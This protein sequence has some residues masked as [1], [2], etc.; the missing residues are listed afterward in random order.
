MGGERRLFEAERHLCADALLGELR[1][2]PSYTLR[3]LF[4]FTESAPETG[5]SQT[6][7]R[8]DGNVINQGLS[9]ISAPRFL[10]IEALRARVRARET[11]REVL[12][13]PALSH[14]FLGL[15]IGCVEA[16][17]TNASEDLDISDGVYLLTHLC[18]S[19]SAPPAPY[20][21]C[22]IADLA[23][24][25]EAYACALPTSD[26]PILPEVGTASQARKSLQDNGVPCNLFRMP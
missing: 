26:S 10:F 1:L 18:L 5:G 21:D 12:P 3:R 6:F 7:D 22:G 14:L 13:V 20:P 25:C 11:F 23:I 9:M 17:H 2:H 19:G 24:E 15:Q 8:G 4:G 16:V